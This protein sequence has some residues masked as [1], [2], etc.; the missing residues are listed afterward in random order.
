MAHARL[1]LGRRDQSLLDT[2]ADEQ[3]RLLPP[4]STPSPA[5]SCVPWVPAR[6]RTSASTPVTTRFPTCS[7]A[8]RSPLVASE[9][10]V[11]LLDDATEVARLARI[12]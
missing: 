11:R 9:H 8:A 12:W 2:L 4:S 1:V 5:N 7:S 6:R 3:P 10:R